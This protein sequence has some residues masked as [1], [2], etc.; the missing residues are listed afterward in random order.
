MHALNET[1]CIKCNAVSTL[2]VAVL[3]LLKANLMTCHV[4]D[5]YLHLMYWFC[6]TGRWMR[7]GRSWSFAIRS[8][9]WTRRECPISIGRSW[10]SSR[11]AQHRMVQ[12]SRGR[13][14][15][16]RSDRAAIAARSNRDRGT[17][18]P[19]SHIFHRRITPTGSDSGRPRSRTT[20]DA[21]SWPDRGLIVARSCLDR[22][23]F[24]AKFKAI[25]P[26]FQAKMPLSANRSH[27]ALIPPP[28][29]R[30][31][32]MIFGPILPLKSHVFPFFVL[33]LL[34][35]S[36]RQLYE[37]QGRSLVHRDSPAFRLNCDAS[38]AGLI[39]NFPLISSNFPLEF[40]KSARKNP[41]KF[42]SIYKNWSP[43]LVAIGLVVRFD[44]LS[45]GNL[46][47]Y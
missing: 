12:T 21:R 8:I 40:R 45:G 10:S 44:R 34:I 29:T 37:F 46:S 35:D 13:T 20:I 18:E 4:I 32:P 22:A 39:A 2:Y 16:S 28:R 19:R 26:G 42:A 36:W 27:D 33:Q 3:D 1:A 43:I 14:P 41:S 17:I 25:H 30:Q 11:A 15:R 23:L 24:E 6:Y 7:R 31:L 38:G 47:F 9:A 5:W